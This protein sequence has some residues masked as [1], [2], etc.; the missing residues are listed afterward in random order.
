MHDELEVHLDKVPD[1]EVDPGNHLGDGR[2]LAAAYGGLR[3]YVDYSHASVTAST[4]AY[5]KQIMSAAVNYW[6]KTLQVPQLS[7]LK[8]PESQESMCGGLTVPAA[9]RTNGVNADMVFFVTV[10]NS[11]TN[12]LAWSRACKQLSGTGRPVVGQVNF[13]LNSM[14]NDNFNSDLMVVL[15]E[16]TH[17]LGFSDSLFSSFVN[18]ARVGQTNLG[19][20]TYNYLS[21]EPLNTKLKNFFGCSSIPGA[22]L[23]NQGGSGSAGS[24]WE[25]RIFGNEYMTA[26]QI[27][28][29]RISELTLALLESTG[30]Y[31]VD[32]SMADTFYYGYGEGCGYLS[33]M[34]GYKEYCSTSGEGCTLHGQAGGYCAS[35]SFSDGANYWRAY[36]NRD[37]TLSSSASSA[38]IS[39]ERYGQSSK[40]FTGS[41]GGSASSYCLTYTCSQQSN[42]NYVLDVHLGSATAVC[43]KKGN[44]G[45]SGYSG[46]LV[47]PDP[48]IYCSTVGKPACR[49]G[50]MG[51][52]TCTG[53]VCACYA[54]WGGY[55][56]S[57]KVT[58]SLVDG[59]EQ[60]EKYNYEDFPDDYIPNNGDAP[61]YFGEGPNYN[62]DV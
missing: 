6:F 42:G 47:C 49:R 41:L 14:K 33:A 21:V 44:V 38:S 13:N 34:S 30:W 37:C 50:C 22:I 17:A 54:G 2:M 26:S 35:D 52:G 16:M 62:G 46:V 4:L 51:K 3:L 10:E 9:Y 25:R 53:G 24:H 57:T 59:K 19:G 5:L 32:Y 56:C 15:H 31:Q 61:E 18:P 8:I 39:A 36:S 60:Q 11:Y 40:C 1:H 20:Y 55:D 28:D 27:N 12:F 29:Q 48:N 45:V 43:T 58:S 23:E 7:V